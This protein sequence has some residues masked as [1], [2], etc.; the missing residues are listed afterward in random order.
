M[1]ILFT[2]LLIH[3]FNLDYY[4][5]LFEENRV[6]DNLDR[7]D[8]II[9]TVSIFDLFKHGKEIEKIELKNN[10]RFFT[11]EEIS[12]LYDVRTL[13][14]KIF[15][16]YYSCVILIVL[17]LPFLFEKSLWH[18]IK[19]L[20]Q[21]FTLASSIVLGLGGLLYFLSRNFGVLFEN[22]HLIFFPQGNYA[23]PED[24]LIITLF[25][26]GFFY[27]FFKRLV[28]E[29]LILSVVFFVLGMAGINIPLI[30][31]PANTPKK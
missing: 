21:I 26:E 23:F 31:R 18:F 24:S 25:P 17:C 9:L 5:K 19:N 28:V 12:H 11:E 27:S 3:V 10:G 29:T 15:V 14:R 6:F 2:S 16:S 20:G 22:F 30:F 7:E 4:V 1:V 8:A 13:L